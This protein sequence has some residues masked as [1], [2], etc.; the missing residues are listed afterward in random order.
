MLI[1]KFADSIIQGLFFSEG[2]I[3]CERTRD[4][5]SGSGVYQINTRACVLRIGL[6]LVLCA[7]RIRNSSMFA[8][9]RES[10]S[11]CSV[12]V[13]NLRVSEAWLGVQRAFVEE[14]PRGALPCRRHRQCPRRSSADGFAS[15]GYRYF[16]RYLTTEY[17][18][19]VPFFSKNIWG[20]VVPPSN[21]SSL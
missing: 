15:G 8:R 11:T 1:S 10:R 3:H 6:R 7:Q 4:L 21:F 18:R 20:T 9:H 13:P 19:H 16:P 2:S 17:V 12:R 5:P 14:K